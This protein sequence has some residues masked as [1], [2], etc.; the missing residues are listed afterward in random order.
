MAAL[1]F[2]KFIVIGDFKINVNASGSGKDNLDE[3]CNLFDLTYLVREVT[4]TNNHRS[5]IDLIL[6]NRFFSKTLHKRNWRERL[7]QVHLHLLQVASL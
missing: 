4:C 5:L 7:S 3:F 1:N 6:T 2:E